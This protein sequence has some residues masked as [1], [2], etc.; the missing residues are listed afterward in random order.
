MLHQ[1]ID[2]LEKAASLDQLTSLS[3]RMEMTER[4]R[5]TPA[6]EYSLILIG[7]RGLRRCV[8]GDQIHAVYGRFGRAG[9]GRYAAGMPGIEKALL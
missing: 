8:S 4:I 7:V 5:L 1:R 2:T 9:L 6:G 3:N